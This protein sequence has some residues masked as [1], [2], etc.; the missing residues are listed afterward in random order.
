[1]LNLCQPALDVAAQL[2]GKRLAREVPDHGPELVVDVKREP[3]ID[4]P[5]AVPRVEKTVP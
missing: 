2:A 1:M 3:V 4:Y 5:Y